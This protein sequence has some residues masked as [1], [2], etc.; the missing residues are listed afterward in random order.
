VWHHIDAK[1]NAMFRVYEF[2]NFGTPSRAA[3]PQLPSAVLARAV[4]AH[5]S[6][7]PFFAE[8]DLTAMGYRSPRKGAD[9]GARRRGWRRR[10]K[11]SPAL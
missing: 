1:E 6:D 10:T 4:W 7:D 5:T 9:G 2:T 3:T 8:I 11:A